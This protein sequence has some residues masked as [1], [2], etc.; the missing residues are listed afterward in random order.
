MSNIIIQGNE[1]NA[2]KYLEKITIE[3]IG[4][5]KTLN[6]RIVVAKGGSKNDGSKSIILHIKD[7]NKVMSNVN[8]NGSVMI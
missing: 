8:A 6:P 3:G 4:E 1:I 5:E 7:V 2:R